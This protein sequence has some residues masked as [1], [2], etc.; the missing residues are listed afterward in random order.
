MENQEEIWLPVVGY[1]GFYEVS[2][3][4]RVKSV[5][6]IV[7]NKAN[8]SS[9]KIKGTLLK[10]DTKSKLYAQVHLCVNGKSTPKLYI[11]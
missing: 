3:L 4:G 11:G 2:N 10:P 6:R 7:W 9:S 1:E 5:D 8:K